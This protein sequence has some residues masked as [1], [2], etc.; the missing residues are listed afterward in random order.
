E[1][2]RKR[3]PRAIF[4]AQW[5]LKRTQI[6]GRTIDA[7]AGVLGAHATTLGQGT[8]IAIID[9]GVDVDHPEFRA[10]GKVVAPRDV[11]FAPS[12]PH[13]FDARPKDPGWSEDHGTAC[14]GVACA[15]GVDGASGV[16]PAA[17]L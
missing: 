3:Q 11:M 9:D 13:A 1:L 4:D 10:A 14:A 17:Q 8:V 2:V 12:H 5:H 15:A 16:A 6:A 7:H